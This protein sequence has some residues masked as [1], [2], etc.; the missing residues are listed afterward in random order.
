MPLPIFPPQSFDLTKSH[1]TYRTGEKHS[2][3]T[4]NPKVEDESGIKNEDEG[5][6]WQSSG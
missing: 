3:H 5:L 4:R 1:L 6:P 2:G